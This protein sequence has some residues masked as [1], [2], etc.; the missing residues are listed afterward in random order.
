MGGQ[1]EAPRS[2]PV[3]TCYNCGQAG[4]A[5]KECPLPSI[6]ASDN[7]RWDENLECW[8]VYSRRYGRWDPWHGH[9]DAKGGKDGK[10]GKDG[11]AKDGK[12]KS[13]DSSKDDD[14]K[15]VDSSKDDD[16]KSVGS[17]VPTAPSVTA[18]SIPAPLK[19]TKQQPLQ[20]LSSPVVAPTGRSFLHVASAGLPER[21]DDEFSLLSMD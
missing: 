2:K 8:C 11:K 18:P 15:S 5:A 20:T 16:A 6:R 13:V 19:W 3:F 12:A 1:K 10:D 17:S 21:E 9:G 7:W 4:H 14:A